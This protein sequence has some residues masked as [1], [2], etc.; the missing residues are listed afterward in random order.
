MKTL[1]LT[2]M[3]LEEVSMLTTEQNIIESKYLDRL[4][5]VDFYIPNNKE[6]MSLLLLNDGQNL[7]EMKFAAML[8]GLYKA[9]AIEPLLCV[10]IHAG[11]DRKMEYGTA[12]VLDYQGRGAKAEAY[13][14]FLLLELLPLIQTNYGHGVFKKLGFAGFSL[15]GLN[16][17]DTVWH[18]PELFSVAGVFSGS[19]W[20]RSKDLEEDYNEETDRIM[21]QLIKKREYVAGQKFYFTTGSLDETAD[22]NNNGIIDSIDDTLALI[23]EL[24]KL[25][26]HDMDIEYKNY[27]DGKHDVATWARA[28]PD[29]LVWAFEKVAHYPPAPESC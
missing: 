17:L 9:T 12:A 21:H 6:G 29:F 18:H 20:W 27:E 16:A 1:N 8:D 2:A 5:T 11:T 4:V 25:G 23:E 3:P 24:K 28:L 14:Q 26:Y 13:Q 7:E 15:G 10:G 22:R 19:L